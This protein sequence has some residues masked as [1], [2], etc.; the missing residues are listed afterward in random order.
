[1]PLKIVKY[2]DPVLFRKAEAVADFDDRL[3]ELVEGMFESM[4]AAEGVG[5]AAP[6]VGVSLRVFVVNVHARATRDEGRDAVREFEYVF[7]N[8]ELFDLEGEQTGSEGCLSIPGVG[9]QVKRANRLHVRCVDAHGVPKQIEAEG[10]FARAIQHEY[11]HLEGKLFL[12][13]LSVAERAL[14]EGP[15]KRLRIEW[16]LERKQRERKA[17]KQAPRVRRPLKR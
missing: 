7:V 5:L 12:D 13:H 1:M 2:P 11:D 17:A 6:Q 16:E 10:Y 8:P 3:H 14:A 9:G 4:Y 15:L